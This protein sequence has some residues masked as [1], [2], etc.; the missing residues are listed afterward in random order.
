LW[1]DQED[2]KKGKK[3]KK[4]KRK[5]HS[6]ARITIGTRPSVWP[7]KTIE[8]ELQVLCFKNEKISF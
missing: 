4:G 1:E 7:F 8:F 3:R 6:F 5:N 2:E